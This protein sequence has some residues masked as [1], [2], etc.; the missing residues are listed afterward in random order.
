MGCGACVATCKI[1]LLRCLLLLKKRTWQKY[2]MVK[3]KQKKG[4]YTW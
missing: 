4:F 3:Q 2:P 1:Q